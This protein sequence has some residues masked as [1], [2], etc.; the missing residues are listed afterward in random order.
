M[1]EDKITV[2]TYELVEEKPAVT[3]RFVSGAIKHFSEVQI[4]NLRANLDSFLKSLDKL[5]S[6]TRESIG[7]FEIS[8]LEVFAE[9]DAEGKI[10]LFGSGLQVGGKGGLLIRLKRRKKT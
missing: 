3:R 2:I 4:E 10:G 6:D 8:E 9:V 5:I 7:D 1:S